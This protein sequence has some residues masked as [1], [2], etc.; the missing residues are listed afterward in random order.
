MSGRQL[1]PESLFKLRRLRKARRLW[2]KEPVFAY[3]M[4]L[5]EFPDYSHEQFVADL[6]RRSKSVSKR[7]KKYPLTKYGRYSRMEALIFEYALTGN[8]IYMTKANQLRRNMTKPYDFQVWKN[9][10]LN[11]HSLSPL[12]PIEDIEQ[13]QEE[14]KNCMNLDAA[15]DAIDRC[16]EKARLK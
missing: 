13:L 12:I 11:Y 2:K 5:D 9:G 8:P 3:Q 7:R 10:V 4:M 14:M 6:K 1:S 15:N 16:I